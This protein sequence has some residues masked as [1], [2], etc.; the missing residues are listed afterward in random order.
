MDEPTLADAARAM[1][2]VT[3]AATAILLGGAHL[4]DHGTLAARYAQAGIPV[5]GTAVTV[6]GVLLVTGGTLAYVGRR[7]PAA[8]AARR[9]APAAPAPAPAPRPAEHAAVLA[10]AA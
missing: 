4:A 1:S 2:R 3:A 6:A 10:E 9:T 5:A 8:R 7:R